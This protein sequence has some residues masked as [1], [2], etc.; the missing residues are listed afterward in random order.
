MNKLL[1]ALLVLL[2]SCSEHK[3]ELE[4][5]YDAD[6]YDISV[7][8]L[9]ENILKGDSLTVWLTIYDTLDII[10]YT[11]E[12]EVIRRFPIRQ[13]F[14]V[15]ISAFSNYNLRFYTKKPFRGGSLLFFVKSSESEHD[16]FYNLK[17]KIKKNNDVVREEEFRNPN[18]IG[19]AISFH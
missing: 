6:I 1:L 7:D 2:V 12:H 13:R 18:G 14:D 4:N 16:T 8:V 10:K 9:S 17:L 3:I 15:T 19:E 5:I 11:S